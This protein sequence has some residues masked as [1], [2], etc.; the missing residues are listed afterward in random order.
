MQNNSNTSLSSFDKFFLLTL[1]VGVS[2]GWVFVVFNPIPT[3]DFGY[4]FLIYGP[5][6]WMITTWL[7][8]VWGLIIYNL[9]DKKPATLYRVSDISDAE[10]EEALAE[11]DAFLKETT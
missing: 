11:V 10:M 7:L 4:Y 1:I 5:P 6:G 8:C 9:F 2:I 3:P